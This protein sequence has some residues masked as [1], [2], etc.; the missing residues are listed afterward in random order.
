MA[1]M[2]RI[3]EKVGLLRRSKE[4]KRVREQRVKEAMVLDEGSV[5]CFLNTIEEARNYVRA[6][7]WMTTTEG[8]EEKKSK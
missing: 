6:E 2:V 8:E 4:E 3:T 7:I 5:V 1:R